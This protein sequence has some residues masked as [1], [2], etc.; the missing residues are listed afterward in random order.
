MTGGLVPDP[1]THTEGLQRQSRRVLMTVDAVGGVWQYAMGLAGELQRSGN[2]IVFAGVGP[3]PSPEQR[4]QAE[5]IGTVAWLETPPDWLARGAHELAGMADELNA[6]VGKHEI[7]LVHLN[8]PTQAASL[9]L[10]C[11]IVA[12]SH[13][14]VVTWFHT[15]RGKIPE[16]DDW[17]WHKSCNQAGYVSANIVVAPSAS[18]A[19]SIKASYGTLPNL[20]VVHNAVL[21]SAVAA[22]REDIIS[23]VGR[24][25]DDGK[26]GKVLDEAAAQTTWPVFAAGPTQSP[27]AAISFSHATAL[28]SLPNA[29]TRK[30]MAQSSIFVSPSLY[31]PFGLAA[32][33]A[34][35]AETPLVLADIPTYRELWDEAAL[36]FPPRDPAALAAT[37]NELAAR[38]DLRKELGAA[39][40]QRAGRYTL[41]RQAA[42]MQAVYK[43]AT[44]IHAER[45]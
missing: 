4:A 5:A 42:A 27:N 17:S 12:V 18:H 21:P 31:E 8:A 37:L 9:T 41:A 3:H 38:P 29:E 7:D 11:P 23:A 14:C 43:E 6:L 33:E 20:R 32:L 44:S 30:L 34:A 28:G 10:P 40:K 36:F 13:S 35:H 19:A 1:A 2:V 39:A 24:W 16:D 45:S 15:V 26:N 22:N 25:W